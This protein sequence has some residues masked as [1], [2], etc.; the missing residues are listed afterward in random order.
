MHDKEAAAIGIQRV[1]IPTM[2]NQFYSLS[3]SDAFFLQKVDYK[4]KLLTALSKLAGLVDDYCLK[5]H[6]ETS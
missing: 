2:F 6:W 5:F 4:I 3:E 1:S